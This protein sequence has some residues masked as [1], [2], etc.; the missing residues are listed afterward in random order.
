MTYAGT[1]APGARVRL[2]AGLSGTKSLKRIGVTHAG[3]DGT[4]EITS[5]PIAPGTYRIDAMANAPEGPRRSAAD[6]APHR[7]ARP[8]DAVGAARVPRT[9]PTTT[10]RGSA[11][12]KKRRHPAGGDWP[13]GGVP[14]V[15]RPAVSEGDVNE[16]RSGRGG[17]Y[18][19]GH[20]SLTSLRTLRPRSRRNRT[21]PDV[22]FR[23]PR[24]GRR[25]F[26]R[27]S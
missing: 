6:D 8:R 1:A 17:F 26:L 19:P 25:R 16:V 9:P 2:F 18:L 7:L 27:N 15:E 10:R 21:T 24:H 22:F 14:G 11:N 5:R 23:N 12:Q 20:G 4:W 13:D 3:A